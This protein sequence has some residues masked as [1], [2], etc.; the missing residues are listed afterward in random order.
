[1]TEQYGFYKEEYDNGT[2]IETLMT[3]DGKAQFTDVVFDDGKVAIGMSYGRG[4]GVGTK[5]EHAPDTL[6]TD[7][8]VMFQVK[9]ESQESIDSMIETLLRVKNKLTKAMHVPSHMLGKQK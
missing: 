6:A 2:S 9:F 1:M 5:E 7:T 3:G 8:G 4:E